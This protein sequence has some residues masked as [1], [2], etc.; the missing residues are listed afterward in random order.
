MNISNDSKINK[1]EINIIHKICLEMELNSKETI[2][3][4]NE[5][6]LFIMLQ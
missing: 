3:L 5:K 4:D 6:I 1:D 2:N